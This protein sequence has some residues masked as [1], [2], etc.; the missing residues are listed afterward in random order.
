MELLVVIAVIGLLSTL[1]IVALNNAR[2]KARDSRRLADIQQI[3]R[4]LEIRHDA[5]G[6]MP[7]CVGGSGCGPNSNE[8]GVDITCVD[9][10]DFST[11]P[12]TCNGTTY[13][14]DIPQDPAELANG[15]GCG[16]GS[17]ADC[18]Y[19]YNRGIGAGDQTDYYEIYYRLET[20]SG[21]FNSGV[22]CATEAGMGVSNA[23]TCSH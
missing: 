2:A 8:L 14:A 10:N 13:M 5:V 23:N 21:G 6:V 9:S 17:S 16:A 20:G 12:T 15:T 18:N 19:T 3:R 4:A 7:G 1:A 22:H 11:G